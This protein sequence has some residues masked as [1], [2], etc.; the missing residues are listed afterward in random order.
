MRLSGLQA[1]APWS[2]SGPADRGDGA[3][4][5]TRTARTH[6]EDRGRRAPR[7]APAG[8][9]RVHP[10][11]RRGWDGMG[12]AGG[13]PREAEKIGACPPW[14]AGR[15]L[16]GRRWASGGLRWPGVTP[17]WA[18]GRPAGQEGE[19]AAARRQRRAGAP[20]IPGGGLERPRP[21]QPLDRPD[22]AAR[23][24]PVGR[25]AMAQG[26]AAVAVREACG[27]LRVLGDV[28][29]GAHGHRR[30]GSAPRKPPRRWPVELPIGAQCGQEARGEQR[31]AILAAFA[32]L[33]PAQPARTFQVR[34]LQTDDCT[35]AQARGLGRHQE[36]TGSRGL[37]TQEEAREGRDAQALGA[38]RQPR[39]RREVQR[40][41]L[42]A[43]GLGREKAEPTGSVV[44]GTPGAV[45]VD[46]HMGPV[47][48]HL[49]GAQLVG[50]AMGERREA[51]PSSDRGGLG[52]GGQPV[53]VH[54]GDH[55]GTSRG[56]SGSFA[57]Q[58]GTAGGAHGRH[59]MEPLSTP[60]MMCQAPGVKPKARPSLRQG[61]APRRGERRSALGE[62]EKNCRAA[63]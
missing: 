17:A 38:L 1:T 42:P 9:D 22:I 31:G 18:G 54:L 2:P 43:Q 8:L 44:T 47:A 53:K 63:A 24:Q 27:P 26:V 35:A 46:E 3:R 19:R 30:V 16:R 59:R 11:R 48:A 40:Q 51:C 60:A 25:Q 52:L 20:E 28:L 61:E 23:C 58:A 29:G 15:A 55:L 45:A 21:Q 33:A 6:R 4:H 5:E 37:G 7:A 41:G 39:A 50:G 14:G 62:E 32:R 13:R 12:T 56:H 10:L 36:D 49:G 57:S 34:A